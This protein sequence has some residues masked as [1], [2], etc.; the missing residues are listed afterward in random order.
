MRQYKRFS[1]KDE[2]CLLTLISIKLYIY[3]TLGL[4]KLARVFGDR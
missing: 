2:I 1:Q 4:S 3:C